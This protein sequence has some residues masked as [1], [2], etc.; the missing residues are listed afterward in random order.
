ML[1]LAEARPVHARW[2][3][4]NGEFLDMVAA[5]PALLSRATYASLNQTQWLRKLVVQPWPLFVDQARHREMQA[6]AFGVHRVMKQALERFWSGDLRRVA[7]FYDADNS[8]AAEDAQTYTPDEDVLDMLLQEPSG[9]ASAPSRGDYIEDREGLKC[10]EFNAGGFLGGFQ[11]DAIAELYLQSGPTA[12]FLQRAAR[13]ARTPG[14]L[15]A[16]FRHVVEDTIRQGMWTSGPFN[17]GFMIFPNEPDQAELHSPALYGQAFQAVLREMGMR[18][19]GEMLL[20]GAEDFGQADGRMTVRGT[21]VHALMEHHD[22]HGDVR[23]PF[24]CFKMGRLNLFSGPISWLISDKRNLALVSEGADSDDFTAADRDVIRAH[25]PWTRRVAPGVATTWRGRPLRIPDDLP[26]LR[27]DMVLKKASSIGGRH[28][29]V[30]R[31]RTDAQWQAAIALA[32]HDRDWIVQE[33]LETV[34]YHFQTGDQ[35]AGRHDMVWG[36]FVFGAHY[37]GVLLRMM[38]VGGGGVVNTN[39]GA[40]VGT[41][42]EL[43]D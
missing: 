33:Y 40:E 29:H 18:G 8:Q 31:F 43:E 27:T 10:V 2:A 1:D 23:I 11:I 22:G 17:L 24:R 34:P 7:E 5:D 14:T 20:C 19:G 26:A 16:L 42:L 25:V 15:R 37:G 12:G 32:L 36:I 21:P 6:T 4:A 41:V 30:G 13:R 38:P 35:G 9:L 3:Q 28:V 39:Q